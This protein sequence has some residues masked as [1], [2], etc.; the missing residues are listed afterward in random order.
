MW[1]FLATLT[2]FLALLIAVVPYIVRR[3]RPEKP[4]PVKG[5]STEQIMSEIIEEQ[6]RLNKTLALMLMMSAELSSA[7][8]G[9][10]IV[11]HLRGRPQQASSSDAKT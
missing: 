4:A 7:D 2:G 3:V 10:E 9:L 5:K 6:K 1:P 11:C 8:Q